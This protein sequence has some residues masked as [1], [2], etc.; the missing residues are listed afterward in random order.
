MEFGMNN[1]III[2]VSNNLNR[3]INKCIKYKIDVSDIKYLNNDVLT[4]MVNLKDYKT[5]KRLNF[6]SDIKIIKYEGIKGIIIHLK[7]YLYYY[8]LM[9]LCFI[10]MDLISSYII[11]IEV[12]HENSAIR[13]L[14]TNELYNHGIKKYSLGY[15]YD[16]LMQIKNDIL[17]DNPNTIEWMSIN[18]VGMKYI[19]RVEERIIKDNNYI[20]KPRSI[21]A[22]KDALI[23]KV[24]SSKGDILV[25]S[26]D[27]VKKGDILISGFIYF[28][29]QIKSLTSANGVVYGNV[30][31]EV[32]IRIPKVKEEVITTGKERY[33]LIINNK[34][35][36][37]NKYLLFKQNNI[38]EIKLL[39]L[40]IKIFKEVEYLKKE[41]LLTDNELNK[42]LNTKIKE[43]FNQKL[44]NNGE[45]VSQ[46]VLKKVENN[47]TIEYRVFVIT[48]EVISDYIYI[49]EGDN[50]DSSKSN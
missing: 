9:L 14:I 29:D 13:K 27:Y 49:D 17:K 5:I 39:G 41:H 11:K 16:T 31:Y 4:C 24:I 40:K 35:L 18:R 22:K 37:K 45:I 23:T 47:S 2:K 28:N 20:D 48:N 50:N 25:R 43:S 34:I 33:N 38:K 19:I 12:I 3:F 46:K 21:I 30:W 32:L 10:W 6:Y 44:K 7:K 1:K 8:I 15:N 42:E 26:G 36:L